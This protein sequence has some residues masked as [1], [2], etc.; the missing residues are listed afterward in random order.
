MYLTDY[1]QGV[2]LFGTFGKLINGLVELWWFID[3]IDHIWGQVKF[4]KNIPLIY[5][6]WSSVVF[7]YPYPGLGKVGA[8]SY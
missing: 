8:T 2:R 1:V 6:L 3:H 4:E 7:D 5:G